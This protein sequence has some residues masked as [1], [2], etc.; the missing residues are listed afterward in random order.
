MSR[1]Q[2]DDKAGADGTKQWKK[3]VQSPSADRKQDGWE[4][5]KLSEAGGGR[6]SAKERLGAKDGQTSGPDV[7]EPHGPQCRVEA[8]PDIK[9]ERLKEFLGQGGPGRDLSRRGFVGSGGFQ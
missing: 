4:N 6:E 5:R 8:D 7:T 2:P 3:H 1:S 9:R